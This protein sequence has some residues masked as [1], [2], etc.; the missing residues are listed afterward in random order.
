MCVA[1]GCTC[2]LLVA[3]TQLADLRNTQGHLTLT[4]SLMLL[5]ED[6]HV[7]AALFQHQS[8]SSLPWIDD[9]A[10]ALFIVDLRRTLL[11]L[12]AH[13]TGTDQ[14]RAGGQSTY[15]APSGAN[16]GTPS[17]PRTLPDCLDVLQNRT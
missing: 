5:A 4:D 16:Y 2:L 9:F 3:S 15:F 13:L 1:W 8:L 6:V 17:V 10:H 11:P 14:L 12:D 7:H